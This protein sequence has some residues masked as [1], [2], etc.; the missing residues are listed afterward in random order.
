MARHPLTRMPL[1]RSYRV[2]RPWMAA[3]KLCGALALACA[4]LAQGQDPKTWPE[5][6]YEKTQA[7]PVKN[8]EAQPAA[9]ASAQ[10]PAG[11]NESQT[12]TTQG[13]RAGDLSRSAVERLDDKSS[14]LLKGTPEEIETLRRII[15]EIDRASGI[16]EPTLERVDLKNAEAGTMARLLTSVYNA[17]SGARG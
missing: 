15:E 10:P 2:N 12:Q 6:R 1:E 7:T 14:L 16:A 3:T 5:R 9:G 17:K 11:A 13:S 8:Q 4:T